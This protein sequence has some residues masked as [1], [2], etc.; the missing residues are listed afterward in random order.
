LPHAHVSKRS[1]DA[2]VSPM[3]IPAD[4]QL[5]PLA[6]YEALY[7]SEPRR[8][9]IPAAAEP[10]EW[11]AWRVAFRAGLRDRL[12][13]LPG[14]QTPIAFTAA[15][16]TTHAGYRRSYLEYES[17]PGVTV[18]AWLL[19]PEGLTRA[20]PA[21]IAVHGHGYGMDE[22]VGINADGTERAEPRGYHQDF[23]LALC[24]RGMV[25][26]A[27]ELRAF[28]RR[29]EQKDRDNVPASSSCAEAAWW[30][31]MLGQPLLGSRVWDV[32]RAID[33]IQTLPEVD[34]RRIGIMGGSGGGAVTLFAAALEARFR[35]VVVSNYFCT[36]KDSVLAIQHCACN[37]VP[38]LLEDAEMYDVAALIAPRPLL[39]EA[40]TE[41]PIFPLPG[42]LESYERLRTAYVAQGADARLDKDVFAGGHQ[43]SGAKAYDF[44]W[45]WLT[46]ES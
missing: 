6:L 8:F 27:P 32:L 45:H 42:V 1:S 23:A 13:G 46:H 18:P 19:I 24:R 22:L 34:G 9:A 38:G 21:V 37:Y 30:G 10:V 29:R 11:E 41:D 44:L 43:I 17:A 12:G 26:L 28:G 2:V 4:E 15:P 3:S 16:P 35:A 7:R 31:I 39:I 33:L 20:A 5:R 40:G 36:F 14:E 25:V